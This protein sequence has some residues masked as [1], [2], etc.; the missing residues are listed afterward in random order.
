MNNY[1]LIET[2]KDKIYDDLRRGILE[3]PFPIPTWGPTT[4]WSIVSDG[5]PGLM[6]EIEPAK[7][8]VSITANPRNRKLMLD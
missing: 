6:I 2:L 8:T 1:D 5:D 7:E 3:T 4:G